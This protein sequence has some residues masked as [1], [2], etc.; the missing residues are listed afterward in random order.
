[1]LRQGR[2]VIVG[3]VAAVVETTAASVVAAAAS[4]VEKT[5]T[6]RTVTLPVATA[7]QAGQSPVPQPR[8]RH[9]LAHRTFPLVNQNFQRGIAAAASPSMLDC[10]RAFFLIFS[11][12]PRIFSLI[13]SSNISR[14]SI[15]ESGIPSASSCWT[16]TLPSEAAPF[17]A[18]DALRYTLG[19]EHTSV[20]LL[21]CHNQR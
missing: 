20:L 13:S 3:T 14:S 9:R 18:R 2:A 7:I 19:R 17:F 16:G 1:M 10:D 6:T 11:L 5:A 21:L 4:A 15:T 12:S 8:W